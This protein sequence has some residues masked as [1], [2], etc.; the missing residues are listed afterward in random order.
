MVELYLRFPMRKV[1]KSL[2]AA[3][4]VLRSLCS[5]VAQ[6]RQICLP[7]YENQNFIAMFTNAFGAFV[8]QPDSVHTLTPCFFK[9]LSNVE[10]NFSSGV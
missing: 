1:T 4:L 2:Y 10:E 6:F 3:G 8:T 5:V 7:F 9:N